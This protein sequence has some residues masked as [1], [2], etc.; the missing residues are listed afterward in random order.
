M[1][2]KLSGTELHR[3]SET[4]AKL[5]ELAQCT[6]SATDELCRKALDRLV[7]YYEWFERQG[8]GHLGGC[9]PWRDLY[10]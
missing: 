5:N 6:H 4:E 10:R 7:A 1:T 8:E 9:Q 2:R 3:T